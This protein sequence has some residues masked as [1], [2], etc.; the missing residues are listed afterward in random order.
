MEEGQSMTQ[1]VV[2]ITQQKGG[3]G[4]TPTA[5][6]LAF[7][8]ARKG[9]R[10]LWID[11]D[12]QGTGSLHFLGPKYK[13]RK[14]TF[15]NAITSPESFERV[16]CIDPVKINENLFLLPAHD[17]LEN[18]EVLLTAKRGYTWQLQL[19]KLLKLY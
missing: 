12:P 3:S 13:E 2:A 6:N 7:A 19:V 4:K 11:A 16:T 9:K 14:I 10:V 15:F 5:V 17:E 18:A 8:L 1:K